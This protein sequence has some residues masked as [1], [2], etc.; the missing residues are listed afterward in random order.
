MNQVW[1]NIVESRTQ[2]CK[3]MFENYQSKNK[4]TKDEW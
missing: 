3:D 1:Q 4:E 2:V